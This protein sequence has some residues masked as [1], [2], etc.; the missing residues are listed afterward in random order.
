M[1]MVAGDQALNVARIRDHFAKLHPEQAAVAGA[2][3][4]PS[5]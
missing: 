4:A 5:S 2:A 1:N 3:A